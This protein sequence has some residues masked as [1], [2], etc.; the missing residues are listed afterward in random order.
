[1]INP[2][3]YSYKRE[4]KKIRKLALSLL[5][6]KQENNSA[7]EVVD[8][9]LECQVTN[10]FEPMHILCNLHREGLQLI[11]ILLDGDTNQGKKK[12]L[13]LHEWK[14]DI[15]LEGIHYEYKKNS[16]QQVSDIIKD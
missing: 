11:F 10:F 15:M 5:E 9:N 6:R 12:K 8:Q 7:V 2:A 3:P 4:E 16:K 1:M 13:Q 14:Q